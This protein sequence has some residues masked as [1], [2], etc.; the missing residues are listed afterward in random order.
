MIDGA[1]DI[2]RGDVHH[3]NGITGVMKALAMCE[4]MGLNLRFTQQLHRY[5]ISPI[6]MLD[7]QQ[8]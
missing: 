1:I 5:W 4:M 3:K 6:Y 7:A 2:V 8:D